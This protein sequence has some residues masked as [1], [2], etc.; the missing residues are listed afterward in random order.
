MF[1]EKV[2]DTV[3]GIGAM[4]V[5]VAITPAACCKVVIDKIKNK[6]AGNKNTEEIHVDFNN[7]DKEAQESIMRMYAKKNGTPCE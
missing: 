2:K 3:V 7:L 5:L 4:L 6:K 1:K